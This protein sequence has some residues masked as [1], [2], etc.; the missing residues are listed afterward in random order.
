MKGVQS[1]VNNTDTNVF[2]YCSETDL[3]LHTL[4]L[5]KHV[6]YSQGNKSNAFS[7]PKSFHFLLPAEHRSC[8]P[9]ALLD[10][11]YLGHFEIVVVSTTPVSNVVVLDSYTNDIISFQIVMVKDQY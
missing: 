7:S 2:L 9:H 6:I 5:D 1:I 8:P 10:A 4:L 3:S 11:Y